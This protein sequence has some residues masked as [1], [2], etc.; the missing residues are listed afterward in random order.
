M[1]Q[2]LQGSTTTTEAVRR[3]IQNSK[4]SLRALSARH[5]IDK[6]TAAKWRKRTSIPDLPTGPKDTRFTGLPLDEEAII[7]AFR[8][9]TLLAL[10]DCLSALQPSIPH[11]LAGGQLEHSPGS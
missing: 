5:G 10:I 3:A 9:H 1:G 11:P 6:K 4:E 7:V 2:V 8:W